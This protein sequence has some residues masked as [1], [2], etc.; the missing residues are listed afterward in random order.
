MKS[1]TKI[2]K[3]MAKLV[4]FRTSNNS[5]VSAFVVDGDDVITIKFVGQIMYP[6]QLKNGQPIPVVTFRNKS[7]IH[8]DLDLGK[9]FARTL[10]KLLNSAIV[11]KFLDSPD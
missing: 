2:V 1:R 8:T 5:V 9:E 3:V 10:R 6:Y 4:R 7:R 11:A